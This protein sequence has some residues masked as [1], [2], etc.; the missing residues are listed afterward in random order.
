MHQPVCVCIFLRQF[1]PCHRLPTDCPSDKSIQCGTLLVAVSAAHLYIILRVRCWKCRMACGEKHTDRQ[2]D[3]QRRTVETSCQHCY[4]H[5]NITLTKASSTQ[6]VAIS[7]SRLLAAL[8]P[9]FVMGH[10]VTHKRHTRQ[11][12]RPLPCPGVYHPPYL[13][14]ACSG[15]PLRVQRC[16]HIHLEGLTSLQH[17]RQ[18]HSMHQNIGRC[19]STDKHAAA[20][21]TSYESHSGT[22]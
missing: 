19:S 22:Q 1:Q 5:K 9:G 21:A 17:T 20:H 18:Q 14:T 8:T 15:C 3:R 10:D 13:C 16:H 11:H 6:G 12:N 2:T 4:T 7:L